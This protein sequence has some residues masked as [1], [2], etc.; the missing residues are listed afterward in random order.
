MKEVLKVKNI[1]KKYQ[2][3]NGEVEALRDISFSI[4]E[5]EFVS[6]IG[7]SGCGK[8]TVLSIIAG[9]ESKNSGQIEIDGQIGYMLQ[10]DSLLEW[11]TI[12]K[13]VN[14]TFANTSR[15]RSV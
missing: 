5:G 6:L 15:G 12:Y 14:D 4:K 8:S 1:T 2:A 11:I 13:N 7:P 10:K 9:L 3:E